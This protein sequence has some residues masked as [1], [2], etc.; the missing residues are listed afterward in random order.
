[1]SDMSGFLTGAPVSVKC[2]LKAYTSFINPTEVYY[3][4][5]FEFVKKRI[6]C[7]FSCLSAFHGQFFKGKNVICTQI[8]VRKVFIGDTLN[9]F[10]FHV[11]WTKIEFFRKTR[12]GGIYYK[13]PPFFDNVCTF[14]LTVPCTARLMPTT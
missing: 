7:I 2:F 13:Y 12:I 8:F 9:E 11:I 6:F 4:C 3:L 14:T 5:Y 1:M 10:L